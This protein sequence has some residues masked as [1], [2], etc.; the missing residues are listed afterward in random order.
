MAGSSA[1]AH[2]IYF[3]VLNPNASEDSKMKI[4]R[5]GT[6]ILGVSIIIVALNP[7]ALI[8]QI[9]A[10]AF[11]LGANTFFPLF[12]LGLWWSR[13]T[14]EA[15]IIGMVV[16]LV[17]TFGSMLIPKTSLLAYYIP[18]TSSAVVGV[19]VVLITMIVVSMMTPEP[20]QEIKELLYKVHNDE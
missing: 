17:V 8:A 14:K 15:A 20:S 16:G 1:F 7:P 19:P 9:T 2:D 4:A 6:I 5:V 13:T 3:R 10:V 12:L 11:A 18:F